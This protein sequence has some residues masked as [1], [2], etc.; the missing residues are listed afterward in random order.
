M[1]TI[2]I[3]TLAPLFKVEQE[4][5]WLYS[6]TEVNSIHNYLFVGEQKALLFDCGYGFNDIRPIITRLIGDKPLFIVNSHGHADHA[7]GNYMFP[8]IYLNQ[9]DVQNL[10]D[11]D[12]PEAR[13][14]AIRGRQKKMPEIPNNM[15]VDWYIRQTSKNTTYLPLN[16]NDE[17]D[18]GGLTLRVI[19]TPGHS[20]GSVCLYCKE[21]KAL[22]TGDSIVAHTLLMSGDFSL[23]SPLEDFEQTLLK[24]KNYPDSIEKVWPAHGIKPIGIDVIDEIIEAMEDLVR[25]P[26]EDT[27]FESV[28]YGAGFAHKY[29]HINFIYST[30]HRQRYLEYLKAHHRL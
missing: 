9:K 8:E 1:G 30:A 3:G 23:F 20:P 24:V 27:I 28:N 6:L 26:E 15:D 11:F 17:F 14:R 29:K 18:L 7:F 5:P 13:M 4:E 16:E 25:H 19:E 12:T 21:K 10:L 22:V 2:D